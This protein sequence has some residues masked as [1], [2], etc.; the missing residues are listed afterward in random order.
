MKYKKLWIVV[1]LAAGVLILTGCTGAGGGVDNWPGM[2]V[3]GDTAFL[4]NGTAVY[5][6]NLTNGT[7]SWVFPPK[8]QSSGGFLDSLFSRGPSYGILFAP[9]AVDGDLMVIGN[10]TK[11]LF[12]INIANSTETWRFTDANDRYIGGALILSDYI[13]APNADGNLYILDK[14]GNLVQT[15]A[16]SGPLWSTPV[17][18]GS[19]VYLSGLDHFLRAYD[20]KTLKELWKADLAG[21]LV[22]SPVLDADGNLFVGNISGQLFKVDGTSG[23]IIDHT[24]L[25]GGIWS[26]P[27]FDK[28][29]IYIGV[30]SGEFYSLDE[31]NLNSKPTLINT[32][33]SVIASPAFI[34]DGIIY[35]NEG[36]NVVG[37]NLDL[38]Q[39]WTQKLNGKLYSDPLLTGDLILIPVKGGDVLIQTIKTNGALSWGFTPAK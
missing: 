18:N 30:Q 33:S 5:G 13:F 15:I 12:G 21:A 19:V 31:K 6:V 24:T 11:E 29:K 8:S 37:L 28:G 16:T 23:V 2:T 34:P 25:S 22:A 10:Y 3:I 14:K 38:T 1:L 35:V 36:G 39:N 17:N 27:V 7:Q 20:L 9:P 32:S 4:A 26:K